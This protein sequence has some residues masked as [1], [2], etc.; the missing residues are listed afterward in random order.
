MARASG[1]RLNLLGVV[2]IL[3]ALAAGVATQVP[4]LGFGP[5][6]IALAALGAGILGFLISLTARTWGSGTPA[7]G[8][9]LALAAIGWQGYSNGSLPAWWAKIHSGSQSVA[10]PAAPVAP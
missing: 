9:L 10:K 2:S 4:I 6:P 8:I 3:L 5:M 1:M 7:L